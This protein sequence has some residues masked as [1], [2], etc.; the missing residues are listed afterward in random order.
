M[1]HKTP[2]I[3]SFAAPACP[4]TYLVASTKTF[5]KYA[6][7][8]PNN[9]DTVLEI[10]ASYGEATQILA[11]VAKK[12]FAVE[13]S[14]EAFTV[15]SQLQVQTPHICPLWHDA[16]DIYGLLA[17]CP[18][19]DVLF[20]D[21]GG[22][23]PAHVA[24]YLLQLYLLAYQPRLA[25]VRNI[26]LAGLFG[27]IKVTE[28][29]DKKGYARYK[30]LPTAEEILMHYRHEQSRSAKKFVERTNKRQNRMTHC[31]LDSMGTNHPNL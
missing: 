14:R 15:L 31:N 9:Q 3:R 12:V 23:A 21:I 22:D 2:I 25:V 24:I 20:F 30:K 5:R 18:H 28:F 10:G 26:S 1:E 27:H 6:K 8:L 19:A 11:Q 17:S 13:H 29:P 7:S 4:E 16:R